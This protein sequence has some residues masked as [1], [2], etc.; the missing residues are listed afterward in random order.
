MTFLL[1]YF[2]PGLAGTIIG[3]GLE[4]YWLL[5]TAHLFPFM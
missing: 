1:D 3:V 2:V 5:T 4:A